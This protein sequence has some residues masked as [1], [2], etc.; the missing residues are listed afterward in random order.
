M[1]RGGR[2]ATFV[3]GL[4]VDGGVVILLVAGVFVTVVVVVVAVATMITSIFRPI[5]PL[6]LFFIAAPHLNLHPILGHVR[7]APPVHVF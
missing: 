1:Y 7:Q 3:V 4:T 6:L 2:R 5:S